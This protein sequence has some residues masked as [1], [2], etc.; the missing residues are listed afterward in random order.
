MSDDTSVATSC[1]NT[2]SREFT[3]N[4][5]ELCDLCNITRKGNLTRFLKKNFKENIHYIMKNT[6]EYETTVK[7][8]GGGGL[9]KITYLLTEPAFEI[10]KNSYNLRNKYIVDL[11]EN[12][13]CINLGMCIE[14]QTIG[15]IEN[16]YSNITNLKRQYVIGKYRVDLYFIDYKLVIECDEYGHIDRNIVQEKCRENYILSLGNKLIRYNPNVPLFDLSNVLRDINQ[17]LFSEI[18]PSKAITSF[19]KK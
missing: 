14:N 13:K 10:F 18:A 1:G 9:N 2:T 16:S 12:M 15:F 19:E 17:V 6:S 4:L 5:E 7:K 11:S 8:G 3:K